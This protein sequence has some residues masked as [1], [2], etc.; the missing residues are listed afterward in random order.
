MST[1]QV[2]HSSSRK[3]PL[4]IWVLWIGNGI[5][6]A[7]LIAASFVAEDRGFTVWQAAISGVCG[8][9][10]SISAHAMWYG[11]R[12][13]RLALLVFLT[14][15]LGLLI[16]QSLIMIQRS[17]SMG[18]SANP[19]DVLRFALSIAWLFANYWFLLRKRAR[20]FFA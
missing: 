5:L 4:S 14:L 1:E 11:N 19:A 17:D 6:A 2:V 15:F 7:F 16:V 3:R 13:G 10:I 9:A 12:K 8:L 20:M 18:S